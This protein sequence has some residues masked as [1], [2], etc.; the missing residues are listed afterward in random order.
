MIIL[1]KMEGIII[2]G[3]IIFI[4]K[5]LYD[6]EGTIE[7]MKVDIEYLKSNFRGGG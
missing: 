7:K 6:I 5:K 4:L 2:G 1:S 3:L